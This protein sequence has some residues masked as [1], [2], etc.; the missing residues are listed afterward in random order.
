M[1]VSRGCNVEGK[2]SDKSCSSLSLAISQDVHF[3]TRGASS[4]RQVVNPAGGQE[5]QCGSGLCDHSYLW[6]RVALCE[7]N[8]PVV[9]SKKS[10]GFV[11]AFIISD[12]QRF[13]HLEMLFRT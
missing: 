6:G 8:T 13:C 7:N 1:S 5:S 2:F 3:L 11:K 10:G 12:R 9:E 4:S